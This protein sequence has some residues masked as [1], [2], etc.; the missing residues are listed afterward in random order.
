[1]NEMLLNDLTCMIPENKQVTAH[2]FKLLKTL[3]HYLLTSRD[4]PVRQLKDLY[5]SFY[6][7]KLT[8]HRYVQE[9]EEDKVHKKGE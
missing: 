3:I 9:K 7:L 8:V 1:M 2:F 5:I 4:N 6:L